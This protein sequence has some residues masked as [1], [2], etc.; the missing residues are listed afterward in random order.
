MS[1]FV[2]QDG[3]INRIAT[4]V[5][6]TR[7]SQWTKRRLEKECG[8]ATADDLGRE[9]FALNIVAVN[10]RYGASEAEK[11]RPLD[12]AYRADPPGIFQALKSLKCWLYQCSEGEVPMTPLYRIMAEY[13][14][15]MAMDI[16]RN[17]PAYER[18]TWD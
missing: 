1:A 12:Y 9:M 11:F 2:V 5:F 17:L 10:D 13:A 8:I 4:F 7:D 3:T 16:V 18:A 6:S 15:I 14:G